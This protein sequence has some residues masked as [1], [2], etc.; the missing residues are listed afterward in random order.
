MRTKIVATLSAVVAGC[1]WQE[2]PA[3]ERPPVL[4]ERSQEAVT[5]SPGALA[6]GLDCSH[7]GWRACASGVCLKAAHGRGTGYFCTR[8]CRTELDCPVDWPC[9]SLEPGQHGFLCAVPASWRAHAVGVR[10]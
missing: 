4:T 10:P 7:G 3:S 9:Q 2:A 6:L 1:S 5:A 8:E